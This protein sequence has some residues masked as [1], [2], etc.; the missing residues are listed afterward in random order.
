MA[1][2]QDRNQIADVPELP[3]AAHLLE[4][5]AECRIALSEA[6]G[7]QAATS[8]IL[9]VIGRSPSDAQPVFDTILERAVK[10]C[11]AAF[12]FVLRFD[13]KIISGW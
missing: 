6:H 5:L 1:S 11:E 10:L 13:G 3:S 9:E 12:G 2:R 7:Y 4:E 8:E